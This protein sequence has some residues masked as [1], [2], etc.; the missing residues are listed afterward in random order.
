[1][2]ERQARI[3]AIA[4]QG[5]RLRLLG[6]RCTPCE[7]GCGGRCN[8]FVGDAEGELELPGEKPAAPLQVGDLV[9]LSLDDVAL[10]RS[11]W[12]GYGRAWIG[13][14]LGALLG[15]ALGRGSA[16]PLIFS[17]AP[18]L[19]P[20]LPPPYFLPSRRWRSHAWSILKC[21][22]DTFAESIPP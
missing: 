18:G 5:V 7:N 11:A 8:L 21:I 20:E 12:A 17:P 16:W 9:V 13:L 15:Y 6:S 2:A 19:S 10:R 22:P 3:V 1:M 14:L 4:P